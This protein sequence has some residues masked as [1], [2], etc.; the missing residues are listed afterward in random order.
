MR[1][2]PYTN[3]TEHMYL[4]KQNVQYTI[5]K[6]NLNSSISLLD[7]WAPLYLLSVFLFSNKIN[8][9]AASESKQQLLI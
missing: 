7:I 9:Y 6:K 2:P 1:L 4:N 8:V 3:P 5:K